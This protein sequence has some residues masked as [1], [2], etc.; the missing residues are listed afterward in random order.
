MQ[1]FVKTSTGETITMDVE[2]TDTVGDIREK[3]HDTYGISYDK[4]SWNA[5][6]LKI[7]E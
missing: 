7:L 3:I 6:C 2:A 5:P 1:I 4:Q